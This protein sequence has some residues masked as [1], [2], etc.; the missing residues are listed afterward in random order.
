MATKAKTGTAVAVQ[1]KGTAVGA[2]LP[3]FLK[4]YKGPLGNE[5]IESTDV[6]IPRLKIAQSLTPEVKD[7]K[8]PDGALY[9]NITG[10]PVWVVGQAPL[11]AVIV[12]RGKEFILWRPRED[13]G[14]GILDRAR[15]IVGTDGVTRYRWGK[16]NQSYEVKVGGKVKVVWKT[17]TFIDEDGL[18]QWGSEIPGDQESGIAATVHHNY[19]VVLPEQGNMIAAVSMSKSGVKKAKDVNALLKQDAAPISGKLFNITTVA[20][21]GQGGATERYFNWSVKPNGYVQDQAL[22]AFA[23]NVKK[24]FEASGFKVDQSDG[25]SDEGTDGPGK[26]KQN[27]KF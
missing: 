22:F 1:T 6:T 23:D 7:G 10:E 11:Q 2:V 13:N 26:K 24:G 4:D 12:V 8:L 18:D 5:G 25:Q 15:P 20:E 27:G 19:V 21:V 17:K 16:P 3:D 9:L 14:G